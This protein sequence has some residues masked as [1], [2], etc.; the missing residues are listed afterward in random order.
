MRQ[1]MTACSSPEEVRVGREA[2]PWWQSLN[3]KWQLKLWSSPDAVPNTAI[4]IDLAS[5]TGWATVAVPGNWTMQDVGQDAG[6]L[7][8]YTNV[9]MPWPLRP[10]E[11]PAENTTG[12]YRRTFTVPKNWKSRRTI[13]HIGAAESVHAVFVNG[14]FAGYGTDSRLPSEYDITEFLQAGK[15]SLAIFIPRYSAQSYVE[16]QDQWWMAGLHREVFLESRAVVHIAQL[17]AH[18]DWDAD[19]GAATINVS[20]FI[21]VT[22]ED[23]QSPLGRGW[24]T[25]SWVE[26][27]D[28]K[29]LGK[30]HAAKVPYR[31]IQ[32]YA[33]SGHI[34]TTTFEVPKVQPWSAEVPQR[35][36]LLCELVRPNGE[37]AEVVGQIVFA[38]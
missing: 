28:G 12:V 2:S 13:I 23:S 7:P 29:R 33:F 14:A 15:N 5:T 6:D 37:V 25:R 8:H 38:N 30:V 27:L 19:L 31:H 11:T 1:V 32:P 18:A 16:D 26:T 9:Q 20:A 36:R 4:K 10:P 22:D 21:G 35:Y 34:A 17:H 24:T 3:G